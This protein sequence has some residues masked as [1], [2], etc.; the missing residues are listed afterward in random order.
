[1]LWCSE[2]KLPLP[3]RLK[4]TSETF[5]CSEWVCTS[6]VSQ[7]HNTSF[8]NKV[9]SKLFTHVAVLKAVNLTTCSPQQTV[10]RHIF[11]HQCVLFDGMSSK[12]NPGFTSA[13]S[14]PKRHIFFGKR[15]LM[16]PN[17]W[18]SVWNLLGFT[19]V[20]CSQK[21]NELLCRAAAIIALRLVRKT[22]YLQ[23]NKSVCSVK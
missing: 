11:T 16:L 3:K 6:P 8:R 12:Q 17:T 7:W 1:M 22:L 10:F 20:V 5:L 18:E 4:F 9:W 14:D 23:C 19:K 15:Q 21:R 13:G 2:A